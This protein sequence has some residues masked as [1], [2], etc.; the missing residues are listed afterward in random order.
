MIRNYF[1]IAFRYIIRNKIQSII[2]VVSLTIGITAVILVGL[3][4]IH[5]LSYDKFNVKSERIFR[6]EYGNN[7]GQP[8][9]IGHEIKE[10][11]SGVENVVRIAKYSG[12]GKIEYITDK[13]KD[14]ES[15]IEIHAQYLLCDST[16][17][18]VFTFPFLQGDPRSAL[19][20]PYSVVLTESFANKIFGNKDPVGEDIVLH[21]VTGNQVYNVTGVIKDVKNFHIEFDVLLSMV[22]LREWELLQSL[23]GEHW[24][25]AYNS[26]NQYFTYLLLPNP[27]DVSRT[28]R[29]IN[30]YFIEILKDKWFYSETFAFSLYCKHGNLKLIRILLSIAIFILILACINYVNLTTARASLRSREVGIRKVAGS[31]KVSLIAQFLVESIIISLVSFSI[32]LTLVQVLLPTFN[33]LAMTE[34]NLET[35]FQ[36]ATILISIAG[37][38]LLGVATG[39]YPALYM[40]TFQTVPSI[41]GE[42]LTGITSVVFRR[43][44]FAFQFTISILLIIGVF[45]ILRQLKYMKTADLGFDRELVLVMGHCGMNRDFQKRKVLKETLLRNPAIKKVAF[46]KFPGK[47]TEYTSPGIFEYNGIKKKLN[48]MNIDHDYFDQLDI[49]LLQGR[50]FSRDIQSDLNMESQRRGIILNE[51]ACHE[52]GMISPVGEILEYEDRFTFEIIGVVEDFHFRSLRHKIMPYCYVWSDP[53]EELSIKIQP[54]NIQKT[55]KYVE[56]VIKSMAP[57]SLFEYSFLDESFNNQYKNDKRLSKIISNFAI[58]AILIA[59]LGLFGLSSFMAARRTKEIGIR[60]AMGASVGNV[61][62]RLSR[63]FVKWIILSVIIACPVAWFVMNKWLQS[64]AYRTTI[65]WW[66]F[67]LAI[68]ISFAIAFFTVAWQ[69]WKTARTNPVEALRYE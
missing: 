4:T 32:A 58:V 48:Y 60:K 11:L 46:G 18:N 64:F 15:K 45:T 47:E 53:L 52:F 24:L 21:G 69:S 34:I 3:Y 16:V 55:I 40:T 65:P 56:Q 29:D 61:F 28:E 63:E 49:K 44:L 38:V 23:Y 14:T 57:K 12:K 27:I 43:I 39:I 68:L 36:P 17:F 13:G 41:K 20:D 66:V 19:R 22:S 62:L 30:A 35:F 33:Q 59:C 2:Q 51:T 31:S 37:I 9:A 26:G 25:N 54:H 8:T 67:A 7:V 6:L 42:Q 10:N 1:I 50:N 5:E